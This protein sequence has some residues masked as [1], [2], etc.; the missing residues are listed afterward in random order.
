M[1]I[2]THRDKATIR[3]FRPD[4][5]RRDWLVRV[6]FSSGTDQAFDWGKNSKNQ[7]AS[8]DKLMQR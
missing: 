2:W 4:S 1:S 8:Y 3:I 6:G 7:T 5:V